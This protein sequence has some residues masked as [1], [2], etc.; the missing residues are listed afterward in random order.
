MRD[1]ADFRIQDE[2][3]I[4]CRLARTHANADAF[5]LFDSPGWQ[6]LMTIL[7]ETSG[8]QLRPSKRPFHTAFP[9]RDDAS[10]PAPAPSHSFRSTGPPSWD[11]G[12]DYFP[13]PPSPETRKSDSYNH[14]RNGHEDQLAK[15]VKRF[16][17]K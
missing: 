2:L 13:I 4:L 5:E 10:A 9:L 1:I 17:L 6:T 11:S 12:G 14:R 7:Q 8:E 3:A 16:S 15:R